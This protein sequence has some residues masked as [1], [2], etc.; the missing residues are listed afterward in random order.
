ML[1]FVAAYLL[2]HLPRP[3]LSQNPKQT[4]NKPKTPKQ[5]PQKTDVKLF[6]GTALSFSLT[7]L[8]SAIDLISFAGILYAVYP[9]LF[10]ALVAYA[11]GGTGA[12]L[13]LGRKLVGLNF[14]QEAREA[15]FRYSLVRLRENAESVAFYG[16]EGAERRAL[17]R[18]LSAAVANY[19]GLLLASR[20][21]DVFTSY[22]RYLIQLLPAAVVAPL[23]FA[24]KIE[25]RQRRL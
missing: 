3:N 17:L 10:G 14:N 21:L 22:Y 7:L 12:S 4:L 20:N 9:P 6:T 24:G 23:F 2:K 25:V 18:R 5:P 15:D 1:V 13:L 16:G 8:N 11:A 19:A